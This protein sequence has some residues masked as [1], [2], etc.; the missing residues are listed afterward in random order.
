VSAEAEGRAGAARPLR[1][2]AFYGGTFDPPHVGHVLAAAWALSAGG[3]D[4]VL[5]VPAFEHPLGKRP[6]AAF[7]ARVRMCELAMAPLPGASVSRI[8]EELGG[9]SRTL[10]TLEAL[11]ARMP[12]ASLQL[13]V[14]ADILDEAAR[15][16][17]WDRVVELAPPLV[18]GRVGYAPSAGCPVAL[19]DVSSTELRAR[20]ARGDD[21]TGLVP[22]AVASYVAEHHLYTGDPA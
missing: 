4:E 16:H 2:V 21:V 22:T 11:C 1:V 20:F 12:D 19:P 10:R 5:V 6:A 14:G 9:P 8:E 18:V 13:L 17:R 15:W 7:E 3:V